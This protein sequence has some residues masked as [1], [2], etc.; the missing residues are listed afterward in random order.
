MIVFSKGA[1]F[2]FTI[3]MILCI[4][5]VTMRFLNLN[6]QLNCEARLRTETIEV[7]YVRPVWA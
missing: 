7:A 2:E 4:D 5:I 6:T 1:F 3:L